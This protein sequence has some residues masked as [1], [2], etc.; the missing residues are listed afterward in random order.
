MF[1]CLYKCRSTCTCN[2][3]S[4]VYQLF[5]L[6]IHWKFNLVKQEL[7]PLYIVM[8]NKEPNVRFPQLRV[9]LI[10]YINVFLLNKNEHIGYFSEGYLFMQE[11]NLKPGIRFLRQYWAWLPRVS[12]WSKRMSF[13]MQNYPLNQNHK[14]VFPEVCLLRYYKVIH[15]W[16]LTI[17]SNQ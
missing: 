8:S 7:F 2:Y 15:T 14:Y 1:K 9:I 5:M 4:T 11:L 6:T 10:H 16:H 13:N 3:P 17:L 12:H